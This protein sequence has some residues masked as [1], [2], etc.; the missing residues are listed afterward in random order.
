MV[1][2]YVDFF[3]GEATT[4]RLVHDETCHQSGH[5]LAESYKYLP[6][7]HSNLNHATCFKRG[8]DTR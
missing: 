4:Q 2:T 8:K 6:I 5:E 7:R 1:D 3:H